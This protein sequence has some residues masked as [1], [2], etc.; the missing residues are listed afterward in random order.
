MHRKSVIISE[1]KKAVYV[2]GI[3]FNEW[4]NEIDNVYVSYMYRH[5][6]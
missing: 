2:E 3:T 5:K 1:Y 6:Y 4:T